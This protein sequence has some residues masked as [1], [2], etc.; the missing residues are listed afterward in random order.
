MR[1]VCPNCD[2]KY[3]VPEDAIPDAGRDVQCA[4]CSHAWFQP[5]ERATSAVVTKR[6][7][8]KPDPVA[9]PPAPPKTPQ[10]FASDAPAPV[11]TAA[12]PEV[13]FARV[14]P[15]S[16]SKAE[17]TVKEASKAPPPPAGATQPETER[18]SASSAPKG[19]PSFSETESATS[20]PE[21]VGADPSPGPIPGI[22]AWPEMAEEADLGQP[23][24]GRELDD[25][26]LAILR[27][28]AEREANAR[29]FERQPL[30]REPDL[31]VDPAPAARKKGS[32]KKP[33]PMPEDVPKP[34]AQRDLLPDVEEIKFTLGR[35]DISEAE[36][37]GDMNMAGRD[38]R[39]AFRS[40]FLLVLSM[41]ILGAAVY[42]ASAWLANL[43]PALEGPLKSYV[44]L[45]D[46][47]RLN[48]DS[49][50]QSAT[51]LISGVPD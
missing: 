31:G 20:E 30:E 6:S 38:G 45:I 18:A 35:S 44:G 47:I 27:E 51:R 17:S 9:S 7:E 32:G 39:G 2:A 14:A 24:A 10:T 33:M 12:E 41:A 15:A 43:I 5:R 49:L 42:I 21:A 28:E 36:S 13:S 29:S 1:L 22:E 26:V 46:G 34:S 23:I 11:G 50:M 8:P 48:M 4:N 40:G 16:K 3:E 19:A 37:S 25:S